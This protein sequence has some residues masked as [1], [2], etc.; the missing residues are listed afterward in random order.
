ML[1]VTPSIAVNVAPEIV[2]V[3]PTP[4]VPLSYVTVPPDIVATV[5]VADTTQGA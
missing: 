1:K 2:R 5:S 3:A 4:A